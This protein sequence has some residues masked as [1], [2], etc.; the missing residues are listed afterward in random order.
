MGLLWVFVHPIFIHPIFPPQDLLSSRARQNLDD[1]QVGEGAKML[2]SVLSVTTL[3]SRSVTD[4]TVQILL[5]CDEQHTCSVYLVRS[6]LHTIN[7]LPCASSRIVPTMAMVCDDRHTFD[8]VST[9]VDSV[10]CAHFPGTCC[11]YCPRVWTI[12]RYGGACARVCAVHALRAAM[13]CHDPGYGL[14][15]CCSGLFRTILNSVTDS[16]VLHACIA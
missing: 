9:C 5:K 3:C 8:I 2:T 11:A 13:A 14:K 4:S 7:T 6:V 16:T 12:G 10:T 1:A 15:A